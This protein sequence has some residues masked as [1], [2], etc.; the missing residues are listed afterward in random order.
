MNKNSLFKHAYI[1]NSILDTSDTLLRKLGV[2]SSRSIQEHYFTIRNFWNSIIQE[3]VLL[4]ND[5]YISGLYGISLFI[6]NLSIELS[7]NE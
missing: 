1:G 7:R 4:F 6:Q 5:L 3:L 2:V